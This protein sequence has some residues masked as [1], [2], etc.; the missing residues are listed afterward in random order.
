VRGK[1]GNCQKEENMKLVLRAD[2]GGYTDICNAG[3]LKAIE[4]G[5]VTSWDIMLDC[6]GTE[7]ALR[8]I[9]KYPWISVGWHTHFWGSPVLGARSVP[10]L[11]DRDTGRFRSHLSQ[12]DDIDY[13]EMLKEFRAQ[14]ERC[15]R[16]LGHAPDV[17]F[18]KNKTIFDKAMR[19]AADE[20]GVVYD[21]ALKD[22]LPNRGIS[23]MYPAEK[24][25]SLDIY[26]PTPR[27]AYAHLYQDESLRVEE[28][29]TREMLKYD[30]INYIESDPD[31]MAEHRVGVQAFHPGYVDEFVYT[32]NR[33]TNPAKLPPL[34][35]IMDI[36]ALCSER[37]KDVI[38]EKKI[39]LINFRDAIYGTNEYQE[40][41]RRTGS[42]LAI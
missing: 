5:I 4:N 11:V 19:Q 34:A 27:Y 36:E 1:P 21:F 37:M 32:T 6:P 25:K 13:D 28:D 2:D 12:L 33:D 9:K 22:V 16:I 23:R 31:H 40:H 10:S 39:E 14:L 8:E 7:D 30:P 29:S 41:L 42:R 17:V 24:Y 38:C 26:M 18:A 15:V 35:R 3:A 20:F